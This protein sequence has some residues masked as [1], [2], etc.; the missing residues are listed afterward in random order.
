M[1]TLYYTCTHYVKSFVAAKV[2]TLQYNG[3]EMKKDTALSFRVPRRLKTDLEAVA[4]REGRS[5]SQICEAL[6]TGGLEIYKKEG[7]K[8]L[9]WF[10]SRTKKEN[11]FR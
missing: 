6:L 10:F 11:L 7:S 3:G 5:L 4:Q 2:H 1:H 9:N 8:Y